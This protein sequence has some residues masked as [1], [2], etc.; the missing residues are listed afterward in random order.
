M[1]NKICCDL[2]IMLYL[3]HTCQL[4]RVVMIIW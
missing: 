3:M 1:T 4:F 2:I